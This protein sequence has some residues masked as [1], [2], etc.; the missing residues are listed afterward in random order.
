MPAG[1]LRC[2]YCDF[3]PKSDTAESLNSIQELQDKLMAA[4][5][6]ISARDKALYGEL[7][8]WRTKA[9]IIQ[10]FALPTTKADL[11]NLLV[12][13][14]S[15]YEGSKSGVKLFGDPVREAWLAKAKQAY[16]ML[17]ILGRNDAQIQEVIADYR[18]LDSTS[19]PKP[20]LLSSIFGRKTN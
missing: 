6:S 9:S 10:T 14:Q 20:T 2:R 3:E 7:A 8:L 17:K 15:N 12:F 1:A 5:I 18:F 13:A 4:D 11:L 19:A 16:G